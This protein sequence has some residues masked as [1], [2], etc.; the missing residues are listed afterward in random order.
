MLITNFSTGELSETLFGRTDI[1]QY[2]QGAARIENFDIIPTGGIRRRCGTERLTALEDSGRIIPFIMNRG[3]SFLLYLTPLKITAFA[4]EDGRISGAPQEFDG[5]AGLRLYGS[6]DEIQDVQYAQ[7]FNTMILCHEDYPPLKAAIINNRIE[8]SVFQVD[9]SV[10]LVAKPGVEISAFSENDGKYESNLW[11]RK[12]GQWP[13][14]VSFFNGRLIFAG[15]KNNPQRIF[16]SKVDDIHKFAAYKKFITETR[17]YIYVNGKITSGADYIA[18]D[19]PSE[20]GKFTKSPNEYYVESPPSVA[21]ARVIGINFRRM[22]Q[23]NSDGEVVWVKKRVIALDKNAK[24]F[25]LSPAQWAA[26]E[27][28]KTQAEQNDG[29]SEPYIIKK[30]LIKNQPITFDFSV[31]VRYRN[32]KFE[33][34]YENH[35]NGTISNVR[36][37][38]LANARAYVESKSNLKNFVYKTIGEDV[39]FKGENLNEAY[40]ETLDGFIED[41][42]AYINLWMKTDFIIENNPV[43]LYGTPEQIENQ[44]KGRGVQGSIFLTI[45]AVIVLYSKEYTFDRYP[46]ADCGFTFEIAGDLSDA[47]R[48]LVVNKGLIAG[49]ESGE[50]IIPPEVTAV[51]VQAMRNS[52]YG[53]DRME[54]TAIGDAACFFQAGKKSLVEYYIPQQDN[55]FRVNNMAALST[56]M[57]HES[58][59]RDFDYI[60]SPH[61]R[62]FITRGDGDV[63]TLLYDRSFGVFAWTRFTAAGKV[64]SLAVIPG[65]SGYDELYLLVEYSDV[66]CLERLDYDGKVYLDSFTAVSRDTWEAARAAYPSAGVGACRISRGENGEDVYEALDAGAEPDWAKEGEVYLGYPYRS[67]MRTMP[68]LAN[69]KMNKQRITSLTFRFLESR[70]PLVSS[71]AGGK[72]I[73]TDAITNLQEP[74]SGVYKIPFPGDWD[75]DV[76]AELAGEFPGPV[77]VLSLNAEAQ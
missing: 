35:F 3:R 12:E 55:N 40:I 18:L 4:L 72:R 66:C 8:I 32:G 53:S 21:G 52:S 33:I 23:Y 67:V 24:K 47:V 56:Q 16:A 70:L 63:I 34:Y 26:F 48:W 61:I 44:L 75:E 15:T 69:D 6:P 38:E 22:E 2:Y 62:L 46:A 7:D 39:L 36:T 20:V 14:A 17:E 54:G 5:A 27:D 57:L 11:L 64:K 77:K 10:E 45:E 51:N 31:R 37:I 28:W 25:N 76:Q 9:I 19:N 49:T 43:T 58:G 1:P 41:F 65:E 60:S 13:V 73:K 71:I 29:W 42:W 59:A 30:V 68:V 50:W 74:F